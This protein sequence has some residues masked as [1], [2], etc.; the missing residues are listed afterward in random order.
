MQDILS[1]LIRQQQELILNLAD[2]R[3][4]EEDIKLEIINCQDELVRVKRLIDKALQI[5]DR[6][7][8][9]EK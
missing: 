2:L 4:R 3:R 7:D 5:I 1:D 8:E 6:L 9:E